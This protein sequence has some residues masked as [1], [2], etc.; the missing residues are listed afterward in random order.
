MG[1]SSSIRGRVE[2]LGG[3][4]VLTTGEHGTEWEIVVPR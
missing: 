4:A 2:D 1:I 3:R